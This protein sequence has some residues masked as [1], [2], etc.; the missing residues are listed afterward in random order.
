MR[1]LHGSLT[2][3]ACLLLTTGT[4]KTAWAQSQ[5]FPT[6]CEFDLEQNNLLQFMDASEASNGSVFTSNATKKCTNSASRQIIL[7]ECKTRLLTWDK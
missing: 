5:E 1:S 3:V 2:V 7:L 6:E 4:V